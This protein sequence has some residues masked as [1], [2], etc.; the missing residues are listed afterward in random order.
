MLKKVN[1]LFSKVFNA[2]PSPVT[3]VSGCIKKSIK[4]LRLI[5]NTR[6]L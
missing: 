1:R 2:V 6:A 3:N 4:I 5:K